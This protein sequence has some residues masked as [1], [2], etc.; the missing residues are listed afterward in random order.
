MRYVGGNLEQYNNLRKMKKYSIFILVFSIFIS[1]Q[2]E[3]K[4]LIL[5]LEQGETYS[6][7]KKSK[8]T[9]TQTIAGQQNETEI[10][11][12][13]HITYFVKDIQDLYFNIEVN[14]KSLSMDI[15]SPQGNMVMS[16]ENIDE[17]NVFSIILSEMIDKPFEIKMSK[18]GIVYDIENIEAIY[19]G[20]FEKFPYLSEANIQQIKNQLEQSYGGNTFKNSLELVTAIF[21]NNKVSI[22]DIWQIKSHHDSKM[23]LDIETEFEFKEKSNSYFHI[24]GKS[25]IENSDT[26]IDLE[27]SEVPMKFDL[28]G[29]MN[30]EIKIDN[31]NGWIIN[32]KIY[33][34]IKGDALILANPQMPES[35]KIPMIIKTEVVITD[36]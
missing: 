36:K 21:P 26:K 35:M 12:D 20:A 4:E 1:C 33:Q 9:I 6:Q 3:K 5:K 30:S 13:E 25:S 15:V 29:T 14:Y 16:S 10:T 27:S 11:I 28:K 32:A 31:K 2:S 24:Y 8:M 34:E 23:P 18:T 19:V 22:G 7:F 17:N